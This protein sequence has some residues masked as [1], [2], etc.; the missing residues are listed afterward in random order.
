MIYVLAY[1]LAAVAASSLCAI[2][3]AWFVS[4]G[5]RGGLR[6]L[7]SVSGVRDKVELQ[8]EKEIDR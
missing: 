8:E 1:A 3:V 2:A 4:R 5:K 7:P 6:D